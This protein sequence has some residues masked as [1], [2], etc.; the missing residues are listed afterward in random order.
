MNKRTR[1]EVTH[2]E[3]LPAEDEIF[4]THEPILIL[5][6]KDVDTDNP[7]A[8]Q[9]LEAPE[10]NYDDTNGVSDERLIDTEIE[11]SKST[12]RFKRNLKSPNANVNDDM[13]TKL[14]HKQHQRQ[15][16][17]QNKTAP[18]RLDNL[19]PSQLMKEADKSIKKLQTLSGIPQ[20]SKKT[21]SPLKKFKKMISKPRSATTKP[22]TD[23]PHKT[24]LAQAKAHTSGQPMAQNDAR[25][26]LDAASTSAKRPETNDTSSKNNSV[27]RTKVTKTPLQ[28]NVTKQIV[29]TD[30]KPK[31][32]P[33]GPPKQMVKSNHQPTTAETTYR[34]STRIRQKHH[35][36][37]ITMYQNNKVA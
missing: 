28:S 3:Q 37:K 30:V 36:C 24:P 33:Q 16:A 25:K 10:N 29:Q 35:S 15:I 20:P 2:A 31:T 27:K 14:K 34:R 6:G 4:I 9:P 21:S 5:D 13:Q 18:S 11:H 19:K 22:T 8:H 26:S 23:V 32:T 7:N 12:S 17:I 1:A